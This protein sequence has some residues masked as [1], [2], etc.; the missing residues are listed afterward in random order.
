M[1]KYQNKRRYFM[2]MKNIINLKK[3]LRRLIVTVM[4]LA[5]VLSPVSPLSKS[6]NN[7][8]TASAAT[9]NIADG[10]ILHAWCWSFNTIKNNMAAIAAAGYTS[11]QTSPVTTCFVGNSGNKSLSNWYFHYQPTNYTIGNYQLGTEAEF[12]SMCQTADTYGIK[13]IVDVVQNHMTS[14]YNSIAASIRNTANFFHTNVQI[15]NWSNRQEITQKSLLGLWDNNTQNTAV[16]SLIKSYLQRC[17]SLGADGFRYDAAKH[18]ELPDDGSFSSN[19][20]PN[21]L[22]NGAQFQYGEILQDSV[23]RESAYANYMSV[24]AANYGKK[25]RDSIV[26]N[27]FSTGNLNNFLVSGVSSN[28]LVTWVESHD[29]YANAITESGSSQFM[30]DEQ[31]RLS[32]A[33]I[34]ARAGGTPLFF[35]RPVGGGGRSTD[36][37]FPGQSQIGD[38]GST[39]FMD[40]TVAAVNN[41]RN[42]MVGQNE[43]LRNP[44]SNNKIL[45]IERGTKGV[46]I[47]NLN[48]S[49]TSLS[50]VTNLANGSYT[51]KTN[52]GT[53]TVTNGTISGTLP[54]R[55]VVVLYGATTPPPTGNSITLYYYTAWTSPRAH[56]QI[57]T[58]AWT[59][60][61]GVV[62]SN[63]TV[64]GYKVITINLGTATTLTACF[65]NGSGSWDNNGGGNYYFG[66][67]G[68][69]AVRNGVITSGVPQ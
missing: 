68:T 6:I 36:N 32:W 12:T 62:M 35:S 2:L 40:S 61:P 24:T 44:N 58:G 48:T 41:F 27:N 38:R 30:T 67:P 29:N 7:N 10:A 22:G 65:N 11:V 51:S 37:R 66:S 34:A 59:T 23:S 33:V 52:N 19:F 55:S 4:I 1:N 21:V 28:K 63:S 3:G 50:S 16:Q 60:V 20:W 53:F 45:M 26:A 18:V 43:Y 13:I 17:V 39:L 31:L 14:D 49:S 69:Y 25:L 15:S 64:T 47:I 46:V 8:I 5:M 57:G 9:A 56:Y 54:A 42:A